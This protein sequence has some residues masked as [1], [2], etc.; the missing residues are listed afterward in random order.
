M[1]D[2]PQTITGPFGRLI[3]QENGLIYFYKADGITIDKPMAI[4]FIEIVSELDDSGSARVLVIQGDRVEYTFDAQ[5]ILLTN[6]V[7]GRIAYVATTTVQQLTTELLQD[8][9][10]TFKARFPVGIFGHIEEAEEWLLHRPK[11]ERNDRFS[12]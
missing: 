6:K 7:L 9:A 10:K 2:K 1:D 3:R 11:S 5:Q 4:K 8:L 12:P